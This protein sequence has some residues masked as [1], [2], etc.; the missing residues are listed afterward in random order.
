MP[1]SV[2]ESS[3]PCLLSLA[4]PAV[5]AAF[6]P[7]RAVLEAGIETLAGE[8]LAGSTHDV[9]EERVTAIGR[10][11]MRTLL[12]GHLD[13]RAERFVGSSKL[14]ALRTGDQKIRRFRVQETI[15]W[16]SGLL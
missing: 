8:E 1:C 14:A 16:S 11:V 10:E 9:L 13:L 15:S 6:G 7:V 2:A 12:Q 4:V 3:S 5:G